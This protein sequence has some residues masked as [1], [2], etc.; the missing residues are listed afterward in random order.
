MNTFRKLFGTKEGSDGRRDE[1]DGPTTST[2]AMHLSESIFVEVY[3]HERLGM[4]RGWSSDHL[5]GDDG[6]P[7]KFLS[8]LGPSNRFPDIP[9]PKG[10]YYGSPWYEADGFI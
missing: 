6:D 4:T 8:Q 9:A 7:L 1:A 2:T 3:E 10:Y 5:R